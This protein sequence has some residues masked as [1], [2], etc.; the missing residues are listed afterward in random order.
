MYSGTFSKHDQKIKYVRLTDFKT[1]LQKVQNYFILHIHI[2]MWPATMK[3]VLSRKFE[4]WQ[5]G[6][7]LNVQVSFFLLIPMLFF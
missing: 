3:W 2:Y 1:E 4:I 6:Y 5:I 7:F